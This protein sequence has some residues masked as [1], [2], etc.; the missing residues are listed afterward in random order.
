MSGWT[1]DNFVNTV[2]LSNDMQPLSLDENDRRHVV[3]YP[4][5]VIPDALR[6][7]IGAAIDD[8]NQSLIR[9]FYTYLLLKDPKNQNAHSTAI[10]TKAKAQL[11]EISLASWERFY[12]YWKNGDLE[13]PYATCLTTDLYHYYVFWCKQNG[14]RSTSS[15]KFLTFVSV[16]EHKER[17][18]Y[19]YNLQNGDSF[20]PKSGQSMA[21]IIGLDMSKKP[22]QNTFGIC[23][24]RFKGA[25]IKAQSSHPSVNTNNRSSH[26]NSNP[27]I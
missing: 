20:I 2:F 18:R 24:S 11:T 17:I 9:A 27:F 5:A 26:E 21:F 14:E 22:D 25:I 13:I 23:I 19:Q 15:T 3:L 16:R 6:H 8:P 1:Q 10:N 4:T 12:V 7:E